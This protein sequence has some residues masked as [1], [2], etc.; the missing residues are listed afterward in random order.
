[1]A[2][3]TGLLSGVTVTVIVERKAALLIVPVVAAATL[4]ERHFQSVK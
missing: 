4:A 1:M 2:L 3:P